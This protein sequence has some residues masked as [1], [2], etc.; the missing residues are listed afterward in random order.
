LPLARKT[1]LG[2]DAI[3]FEG[4]HRDRG[5]PTRSLS[6]QPGSRPPSTPTN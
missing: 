5:P 1:V 4:L 2:D 6:V 3:L